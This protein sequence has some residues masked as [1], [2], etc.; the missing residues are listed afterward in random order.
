[1]TGFNF[2]PMDP[3]MLRDPY[4]IFREMRETD[5]IH[6][7][8]L[9]FW[10]ATRY[11]D[12]RSILIDKSFGQGDFVKNIQLFYDDSFDV[13]AQPAYAWLS[14]VFVMQDPPQHTRVRDLVASALSLKR[15]TEMAP[16]IR[17]LAQQQLQKFAEREDANFIT[18]FAY[19]FPTLV[20]CDMLGMQEGEFSWELLAE[21]NQAVADT[22]PV[23]ETRALEPDELALA[24]RQMEFLTEFFDELFQRRKKHPRDDLTTAMVSA[25]DGEDALTPEELS[26]SVI[27]LFG[28][29]F[30][31]TAHMIGNGTI[32]SWRQPRAAT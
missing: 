31:T 3:D 32:L 28:A 20:M 7:S 1:M 18:D 2:N 11:D 26:T 6:R 14:R 15:I 25:G 22:F 10:V 16:R 8:D 13:L 21:L 23:F 30:E 4:P 9:G 17:R 12:C 19:L 24:N 27:G 5:P 29:G